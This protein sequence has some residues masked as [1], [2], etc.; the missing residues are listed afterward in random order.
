MTESS[1]REPRIRTTPGPKGQ[2]RL[3][4]RR[5]GTMLN[6][7][8][9]DQV[10]LDAMREMLRSDDLLVRYN[11]ARLLSQRGDRDAR[12]IIEEAL[13]QG[14]APTRASVARH[15]HRLSWF[16]A[17]P[18]LRASLTD[19]DRRVRGA[20]VFSLCEI[21]QLAAYQ[22]LEQALKAEHDEVLEAA[23]YGL[24]DTSDPAALPV[25]RCVLQAEDPDV[26]IKALEVLG[27]SGIKSAVEMVRAALFDAEADVKYAAVLSLLELAGETWLEELAGII[28]RSSGTTLEQVLR[29]FFHATNY[30]KINVSQS[31]SVDLLL[32][33]LETALLDDSASVRMAAVWP[34]AWIRHERAASILLRAFRIESNAEVQAHIVRVS[35]GLM[36]EAGDAILQEGLTSS[37]EEV[38]SAAQ[39]VI[40]DRERA[41]QVLRYD[42]NAYQGIAM[43]RQMLRGRTT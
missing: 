36:S 16:S 1:G 40:A 29:A 41:G 14:E 39:Q 15:L 2:H 4:L 6:L 5:L 11:A 17:E 38:R 43:N 37:L 20:A 8:A 10:S 18:L 3:S 19:Q 33:A 32:D 21:R 7:L 13:R 22:M 24:R 27:M 23:A 12:L 34:L 28:G 42:E 30:L 26:R 31:A 25:L 35:T 9:P